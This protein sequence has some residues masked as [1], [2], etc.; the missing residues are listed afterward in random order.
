M[1]AHRLRWSAPVI[2]RD[3][4]RET[5]CRLG[6]SCGAVIDALEWA[7]GS[8]TVEELAVALHTKRPRDLRRRLIIRLEASAV[9][10]CFGNTVTLTQDWLDALNRER[11][12]AGEIGAQRRDMAHYAREREAYREHRNTKADP[13]PEGMPERVSGTV[14]ELERVE[15]ADPE[16][17]D[18]LAVYLDRHPRRREEMPSWLA[19]ALWADELV[20]SFGG[21][22][23][24]ARRY[25]CRNRG[26]ALEYGVGCGKG[27]RSPALP[28]NPLP[29][30]PGRR[31]SAG[32]ARD[33]CTRG[34]DARRPGRLP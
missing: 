31:E 15:D 27:R 12:I 18:A 32:R 7:G 3:G 30:M 8:A 4:L 11:E 20:T 26:R 13:L 10:E 1:R 25:I 23:D 33:G 9:V 5:V 22:L 2:S 28:G 21:R 24:V 6:K 19:V 17:V 14:E 29:G 34:R 16:L